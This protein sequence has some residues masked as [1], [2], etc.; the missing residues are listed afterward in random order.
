MNK[1]L[2]FIS[3]LFLVLYICNQF[4]Q[5]KCSWITYNKMV[6]NVC[7][8]LRKTNILYV[9]VIQWNL[10][11]YFNIDGDELR[12][13]FSRFSSSVPYTSED[14]DY[15]LISKIETQFDH[16]LHFDKTP[17][18]SGT[19]A[20]I[21]KGKFD[22]KDVAIK[23]LRKDIYSK[24]NT[25]IENIKDTLNNAMYFLSFF[26]D[27]NKNISK[28]INSNKPLLLDQ[29]DLSKEVKNLEIFRDLLID[30][31]SIIVPQV[32]AEFTEFSNQVMVMEYLDGTPA[33]FVD[34]KTLEKFSDIVIGYIVVSYVS[35]NPIHADLHPGNVLLLKDGRVGIIDFGITVEMTTFHANNMLKVFLA[36]SNSNFNLLVDSLTNSFA[37]KTDSDIEKDKIR[38]IIEVSLDEIKDDMFQKT[39]RLNATNFVKAIRQIIINVQDCNIDPKSLQVIL[40]FVSSIYTI[41][42]FSVGGPLSNT[43]EFFM[44][45]IS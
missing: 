29:C 11:D 5:Y 32:Y 35:S 19:T 13:Y 1:I 40:S 22:D 34:S 25:D 37:N 42:K 9:K 33:V 12:E 20:L 7:E 17:I 6:I 45:L 39:N 3:D 44:G 16:K 14:I 36:I 10:Q 41:D 23:L 38:N 8:K 24:I 21:F 30:N 27:T 15:D 31:E 28:I 2:F 4:I 43:F 26:Y 18:N